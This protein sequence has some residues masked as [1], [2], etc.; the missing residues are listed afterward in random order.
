M[1]Y[2]IAKWCKKDALNRFYFSRGRKKVNGYSRYSVR[3]LYWN[4]LLKGVTKSIDVH[5]E[6]D[7]IFT[8]ACDQRFGKARFSV[9]NCA[10]WK[11]F[12]VSF[13]SFQFDFRSNNVH[14]LIYIAIYQTSYLTL[15]TLSGLV[16]KPF[17]CAAC[18]HTIKR[19]SLL[20]LNFLSTLQIWSI[21]FHIC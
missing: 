20:P 10:A 1:L 4:C 6:W 7:F 13:Q 14:A 19:I 8:E 9:E 12:N 11:F 16:F 3:R 21:Q 18:W 15:Q 17:N 5:A 2:C